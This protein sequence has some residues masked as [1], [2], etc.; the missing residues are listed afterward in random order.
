MTKAEL[1]GQADDAW[2]NCIQNISG[3]DRY[4]Q[5]AFG[6]NLLNNAGLWNKY[7]LDSLGFARESVLLRL[8]IADAFKVELEAERQDLNAATDEPLND[9]EASG[10]GQDMHQVRAV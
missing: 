4:F 10:G 2:V 6:E 3:S 7:Q 9:G 8:Q 1:A 5:R